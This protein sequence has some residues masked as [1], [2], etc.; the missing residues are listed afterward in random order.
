MIFHGCIWP[1]GATADIALWQSR[2]PV[3]P[4]L[5]FQVAD[6]Q[7]RLP[8]QY[9]QYIVGLRQKF[10]DQDRLRFRGPGSI[11]GVPTSNF[12]IEDALLASLRREQLGKSPAV[13]YRI[14]LDS[15]LHKMPS[16]NCRWNSNVRGRH[17]IKVH[18]RKISRVRERRDASFTIDNIS[19]NTD[20]N[21][22]GRRLL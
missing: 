14:C 1:L 3:T 8:Y 2:L 10:I 7:Y 12:L 17:A 5:W 19:S 11:H 21:E 9:Y 20:A 16:L 4:Y 13:V 18:L 6:M 15:M 22:V